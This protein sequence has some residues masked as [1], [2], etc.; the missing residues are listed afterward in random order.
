MSDTNDG[1]KAPEEGT[2]VDGSTNAGQA[3]P[4][5]TAVDDPSD[6]SGPVDL[7]GGDDESDEPGDE[8]AGDTPV[9]DSPLRRPA[10]EP[11]RQGDRRS[12][13]DAG[14]TATPAAASR[15]VRV[16]QSTLGFAG[17]HKGLTALVV[18]AALVLLFPTLFHTVGSGMAER[19]R[20]VWSGSGEAKP[21]AAAPQ[22]TAPVID[23]VKAAADRAAIDAARG[24]VDALKPLVGA[25]QTAL[26]ALLA[27]DGNGARAQ[28]HFAERLAE[29]QGLRA[30]ADRNSIAQLHAQ[31]DD[32]EKRAGSQGV[33][34]DVKSVRRSATTL[35]EDL[36]AFNSRFNTRLAAFEATLTAHRTAAPT[37]DPVVEAAKREAE[38]QAMAEAAARAERIRRETEAKPFLGVFN[39]PEYGFT[40]ELKLD[41]QGNLIGVSVVSNDPANIPAGSMVFRK[42]SN[43]SGRTATGEHIFTNGS[44][45]WWR[46]CTVTVN[47]DGS[48]TFQVV[49][50]PGEGNDGTPPW[51]L[52]MR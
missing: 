46:P 28:L 48:L 12:G 19:A 26:D 47:A 4:D 40:A 14:A 43:I 22:A 39:S 29:L 5:L 38:A 24:E 37:V 42:V 8:A 44:R 51:T 35:R 18:V 11:R 9:V 13:G 50:R 7:T 1:N 23:P 15:F 31:L 10:R 20:M 3:P 27:K 41:D 49:T 6:P 45:T 25:T 36:E 34:T 33:E 32:L 17:R 52:V 2:P 30:P 16:R 21:E